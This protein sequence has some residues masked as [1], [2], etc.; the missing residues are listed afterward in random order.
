[1]RQFNN[2]NN[3]NQN[4]LQGMAFGGNVAGGRDLRADKVR[5]RTGKPLGTVPVPHVSVVCLPVSE[6]ES[7]SESESWQHRLHATPERPMACYRQ[8]TPA[9]A[10]ASM[11]IATATSV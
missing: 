11:V 8:D 10:W 7:I 4:T 5:T 1:M 6:S 2:L 9:A 3:M